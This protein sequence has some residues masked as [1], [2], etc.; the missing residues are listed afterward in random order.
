MLFGHELSEQYKPN[1]NGTKPQ[2]SQKNRFQVPKFQISV[3]ES[4]ETDMSIV[5][6]LAKINFWPPI[7]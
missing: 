3:L 2:E 4:S 1:K 5:W 6:K 7:D